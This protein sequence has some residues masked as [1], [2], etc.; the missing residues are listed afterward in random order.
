M[1]TKRQPSKASA[2][3][4]TARKHRVLDVVIRVSRENGREGDAFHSPEIQIN[5]CKGHAALHG[6]RIGEVIDESASVS[7]KTTNRVGLQRAMRRAL[8]GTTDGIIVMAVDRFGRSLTEGVAAIK[9]LQA[10]GASFVAVDN[11]ID[12]GATD[13]ATSATTNLLLGFMFLLAEWQRDSLI[14]KWDATRAHHIETLGVPTHAPFGYR[15]DENTRRL[16][17]HPT[18]APVVVEVFERR[19]R[20]EGMTAIARALN[21]A[22]SASAHGCAWTPNRVDSILKRRTYLGEISSGHDYVNANAHEA[23]VSPELW[24][25]AHARKGK[26]P[27]RRKGDVASHLASGLLRCATCGGRMVNKQARADGRGARYV[28]RIDNGFGKCEAPASINAAEV[29][30]H[31]VE[32]L[33]T[34]ALSKLRTECADATNALDA[35]RIELARA[36][37]ALTAWTTD[38]ANDVL[39]A[40]VPDAYD[41][42]TNVRLANVTAARA[43]V[44][45]ETAAAGVSAVL[46][47]NLGEV[48]VDMTPEDQRL[49]L[50]SWFAV[51]AVAPNPKGRRGIDVAKRI[52][53]WCVGDA[54]IPEGFTVTTAAHLGARR[55]AVRRPIN[56][57]VAA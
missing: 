28:C 19:A 53:V 51:V 3:A 17:A 44:E 39:R 14:E 34:D 37:A 54:D 18:E 48:W 24:E 22:G 36:T 32:M 27:V 6:I 21:E 2:K 42:G 33:H 55:V 9:E 1:A 12:T 49:W 40:E 25:R 57:T 23:L 45:R 5:K 7:G 35:A 30:A 11:G 15:K 52:A 50:S 41:A 8:D 56:F 10:V 20:G 38:T 26:A 29:D 4:R 47:T 31:L 16:V 13:R 43:A 46:P